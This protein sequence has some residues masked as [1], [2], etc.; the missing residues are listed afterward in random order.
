MHLQ[1]SIP[2]LK[3]QPWPYQVTAA[4]SWTSTWFP[5]AAQIR[6]VSMGHG[7]SS[8]K[9]SPETQPLFMSD[10]LWLGTTTVFAVCGQCHSTTPTSY[11]KDNQSVSAPE[12]WLHAADWACTDLPGDNG[13]GELVVPWASQQSESQHHWRTACSFVLCG[14]LLFVLRY[15]V[16]PAWLF[17]SVLTMHNSPCFLASIIL[18]EH[19]I[20]N[21]L[22]EISGCSTISL[23]SNIF[24]PSQMIWVDLG[25]QVKK[26]KTCILLHIYNCSPSGLR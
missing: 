24:F 1:S 16:F 5:A 12:Q 14:T 11:Q 18:V 7:I 2:P 8:W 4:G 3:G 23:R 13:R 26:K 20:Q 9:L 10:I 15:D 21:G 6:V 19:D 17:R 25:H 22:S